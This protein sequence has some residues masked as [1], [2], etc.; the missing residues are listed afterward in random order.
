MFLQFMKVK[1]F[2]FMRFSAIYEN[3]VF[4]LFF[5]LNDFNTGFG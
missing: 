4:N 2:Q 1:N 3:A 5:K